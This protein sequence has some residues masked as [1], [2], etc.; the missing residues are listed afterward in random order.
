M[1][2]EENYEANIIAKLVASATAEM[3]KDMLVETVEVLCTERMTVSML[4]E[5]ED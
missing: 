1:P 2:K 4:E 5:R 3:P